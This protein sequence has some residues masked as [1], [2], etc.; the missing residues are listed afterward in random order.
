MSRS[1]RPTQGPPKRSAGGHPSCRGLSDEEGGALL[2]VDAAGL[3]IDH[4]ALVRPDVQNKHARR[5]GRFRVPRRPRRAKRDSR[6][7]QNIA[8]PRTPAV[9]VR[10]K[11]A[12]PRS[13]LH[14]P[15]AGGST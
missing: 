5:P 13:V 11:A 6:Q 15:A 8:L 1:P 9:S 3:M 14:C 4:G 2:D 12:L 10:S 7:S